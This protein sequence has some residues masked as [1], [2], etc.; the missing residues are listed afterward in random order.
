VAEADTGHN[1]QGTTFSDDNKTVLMQCATE[2]DIE[3]FHFDGTSLTR[4][5]G[6][7][8]TFDSR[9]GAIATARTR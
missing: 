8:L 5:Q 4:D 9:P 7:T 1:C 2:K 3:V 6:A